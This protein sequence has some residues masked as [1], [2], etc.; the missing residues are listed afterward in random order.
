MFLRM[1]N[2]ITTC[3]D[4]ELYTH[5]V[6]YLTDTHNTV[7]HSRIIHSGPKVERTHQLI[8]G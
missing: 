7:A 8:N 1:L 4:T 6:C 5:K 3:P 2:S